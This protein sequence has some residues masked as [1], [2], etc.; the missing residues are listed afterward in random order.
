M[1]YQRILV[2]QS[3]DDEITHRRKMRMEHSPI[4]QNYAFDFCYA[5]DLTDEQKALPMPLMMD[6]VEQST[7]DEGD[8]LERMSQ[9]VLTFK[10]D[11]LIVHAGFV[12]RRFPEE[13][14]SALNALKT[15]FPD[16]DMAIESRGR[17]AQQSEFSAI[18]ESS[19]EISMLVDQIF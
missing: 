8:L 6:K 17:F 4:L 15:R 19:T 11:L 3:V 18:F 5:I 14:L 12:F 10:P 1:P 9:K 2:L 7:I 13:M 16:L